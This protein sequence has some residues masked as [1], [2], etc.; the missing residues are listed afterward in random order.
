MNY[1][2][3]VVAV[4]VAILFAWF[5]HYLKSL[6]D[7]GCECA[8]DNRRIVLMVCS[9]I[10]VLGRIAIIFTKLPTPIEIGLSF[11]ATV[12]V[13][14]TIYYVSYLRKIK[15]ECSESSARTTMFYYAWIT[16]ILY[17]LILVLLIPVLL[18]FAKHLSRNTFQP[19]TV[20]KRRVRLSSK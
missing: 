2:L 18:I 7:N 11:V 14:T 4:L 13:V 17:I 1:V 10:I 3:T 16:V 12:F 9:A 6:E 5:F 20:V 8:L 15:C 19:K